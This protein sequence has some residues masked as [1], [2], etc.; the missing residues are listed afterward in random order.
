M[1]LQ[2]CRSVHNF[3]LR[4][5]QGE[6]GQYDWYV[7]MA[8]HCD[9]CERWEVEDRNGKVSD[10]CELFFGDVEMTEGR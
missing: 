10:D 4:A 2:L 9:E 7:D 1:K 6:E 8:P 5:W 3:Y